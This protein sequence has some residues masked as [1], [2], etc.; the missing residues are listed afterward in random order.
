MPA[1]PAS[2]ALYEI[3]QTGYLLEYYENDYLHVR[4][5]VKVMALTGLVIWLSQLYLTRMDDSERIEAGRVLDRIRHN[6]P[7]RRG[8]LMLRAAQFNFPTYH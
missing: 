5:T 2:Q 4:E 6:F 1:H 7:S 3:E 8:R